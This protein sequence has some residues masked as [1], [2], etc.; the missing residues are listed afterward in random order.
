MFWSAS[1]DNQIYPFSGSYCQWYITWNWLEIGDLCF[2]RDVEH[3]DFIHKFALV[4]GC[5]CT[6]WREGSCW[7]LGVKRSSV[8]WEDSSA[9]NSACCAS[10]NDL[11][12]LICPEFDSPSTYINSCVWPCMP[13]TPV[14]WQA[15][16]ENCWG[17][18]SA[19]W[20]EQNGFSEAQT[21]WRKHT[22]EL[23]RIPSMYGHRMFPSVH[24]HADTTH[25]TYTAY[26]YMCP[27][28][29][30]HQLYRLLL[31]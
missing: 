27:K 24:T 8:G 7:L 19:R 22:E 31:I 23:S 30:S 21:T 17:S 3:F 28:R 20:T 25:R 26:K 15:E 12:G 4:P 11:W 6:G 29:H 10:M 14:L 18:W 16:P 13:T 5:L 1:E 2:G 9:D